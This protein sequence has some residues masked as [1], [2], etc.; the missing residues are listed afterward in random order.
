MQVCIRSEFDLE[1]HLAVSSIWKHEI[2]RCYTTRWA[3]LHVNANQNSEIQTHLKYLIKM[4]SHFS[5]RIGNE[6]KCGILLDDRNH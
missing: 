4:F 5:F 1:K 2:L 6:F 3:T